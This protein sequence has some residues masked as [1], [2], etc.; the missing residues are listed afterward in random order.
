MATDTTFPDVKVASHYLQWAVRFH[1][2]DGRN[3][4][5][6]EIHRNNFDEP[7]NQN[8]D[9]GEHGKE[10][11]LRFEP[12]MAPWIVAACEVLVF[13]QRRGLN[14]DI[15]NE[16]PRASGSPEIERHHERAHNVK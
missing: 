13:G 15:G 9:R 14:L 2:G 8:S 7:A 11:R 1:R 16:D 12:A 4:A 5:L 6:D 10:N 3:I